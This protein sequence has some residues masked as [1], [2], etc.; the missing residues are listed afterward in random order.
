MRGVKR[1]PSEAPS[2]YEDLLERILGWARKEDLVRA[3]VVL[4]SRARVTNPADQWSDLDLLMAVKDTTPFLHKSE[5]LGSIAPYELTFVEPTTVA[6]QR[7]RRV[8]FDGMFEVDF[9][10]FP[11]D[12]LVL[13]VGSLGDGPPPDFLFDVF[14]RGYR[15]VL[16]KDGLEEKFRPALS[17]LEGSR[18]VRPP[19]SG[20][21]YMEVVNDFLYHAVWTAKHIMRGELFWAKRSLDCHMTPLLLRMLEW[22][23]KA[24]HSQDYDTWFS[25]RFLERWADP[26]AIAELRESSSR[27]EGT[28]LRSGL[29]AMFA[30]FQRLAVETSERTGLPYPRSASQRIGEW[31]DGQLGP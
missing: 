27:Y 20:E 24:M 18:P 30:L 26:G 10:V 14:G 8:L 13:L 22:H 2:S 6:G 1:N 29:R 9:A 28:E 25:G 4:G 21:E 12:A 23:A 17:G 11:V 19:P 15:V 3:L 31:L 16:D 5:W 7:E